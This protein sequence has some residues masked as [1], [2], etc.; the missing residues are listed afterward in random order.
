VDIVSRPSRR[1]DVGQSAS[2]LPETPY[3]FCPL[4]VPN[5]SQVTLFSGWTGGMAGFL[6]ALQQAAQKLP[7]GWHLR[8]KEHPSARKSL[9]DDLAP[10]LATGRIILD[11]STDSFA[12]VGGSR[13]VV[14]LNSSMGLQSFFFDKPVICLGL[15]LFAI[16]GLVTVAGSQ[17]DLNAAFSAPDALGFDAD[18]RGQ[19]VG[20]LLSAYYPA[21][22]YTR[23]GVTFDRAAFTQKLA[24]ASHQ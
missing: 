7:D 22:Q 24:L 11:N 23:D 16:D 14:T 3:L 17:A 21:F 18:L 13:G 19:F 5:D 20:W 10:L 1:A 12:Q 9:A 8:L 4:Q 2:T 15:S 6:A